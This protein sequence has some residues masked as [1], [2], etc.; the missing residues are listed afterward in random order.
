MDSNVLCRLNLPV[1]GFQ[2]HRPASSTDAALEL[3]VIVNANDD[4]ALSNTD[5][6][7]KDSA[8]A[9]ASVTQASSIPIEFCS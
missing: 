7:F 9:L 1:C 2:E 8:E 5:M 4:A 6:D 3:Q